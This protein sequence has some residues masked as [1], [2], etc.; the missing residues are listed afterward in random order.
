MAEQKENQPSFRCIYYA[1]TGRAEPIRLAAA[2]GG[3]AFEDEFINQQ[4][5]AKTK[6]EGGRRWSG[7]P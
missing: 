2:L 1:F 6:A 7:P 5:Q 3:I 4:Q